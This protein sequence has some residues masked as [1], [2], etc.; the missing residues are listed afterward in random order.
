MK[1]PHLFLFLLLWLEP[2]AAKSQFSFITNS[3]AITITGYAGFTGA[4]VI[5]SSTNGYPVTSIGDYAFYS[6]GSFTNIQIPSSVKNIGINAFQGR[7]IVNIN[8]PDSVTNIGSSAFYNCTKLTNATIS[9]NI[10][11]IYYGTFASCTKLA[12]ITIPSRVTNIDNYAFQYCSGL[13]NVTLS[14]NITRIG[15]L[16]FDTCTSLPS[17]TIPGT[18]LNYIASG[19]FSFCTSL[20]NISVSAQNPTYSSINGALYDKY[21]TTIVAYPPGRYGI[22]QLPASVTNIGQFAFYTCANI[23]NY[24][25]PSTVTVIGSDAF[26]YCNGLTNITFPS[27]VINIGG[28]RFPSL[29][30]CSNLMT[31]TVDALNPKYCSVNGVLFDKNIKTL[32]QYPGGKAGSYT[33]PTGVTN[34]ASEAFTGCVNLTSVTVPS[35]VNSIGS[36][37]FS[38]CSNLKYIM[39]F[40]DYPSAAGAFVNDPIATIYYLPGKTGWTGAKTLPTVSWNPIIQTSH[41]AFGIYTNKFVFTINGSADIPMVIEASTNLFYGGWFP[42]QTNSL[43]NGTLLFNDAKWTNYSARYYRVRSP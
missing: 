18:A 31:I 19:T 16:V 34:I 40:G 13:T 1:I 26:D 30:F 8:I 25:I 23:T 20:T 41:T 24:S 39:F 33:I 22:I 29:C 32:F 38:Y 35:S 14:T 6:N 17:I 36:D 12:N 7:P 42:V 3:G 28:G 21:Q 10:T 27:S 5:P 15:S 37:G 43:T 9:T 2:L 11:S 4:I